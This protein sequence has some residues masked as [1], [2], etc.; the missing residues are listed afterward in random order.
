[1]HSWN[2]SGHLFLISLCFQGTAR[3]RHGSVCPPTRVTNPAVGWEGGEGGSRV[4]LPLLGNPAGLYMLH[5]LLKRWEIEHITCFLHT[6]C[7]ST[8]TFVSHYIFSGR[9]Y[10][11]GRKAGIVMAFADSQLSY[12]KSSTLLF[13]SASWFPSLPQPQRNPVEKSWISGLYQNKCIRGSQIN[14]VWGIIVLCFLNFKCLTLH[15]INI[16]SIFSS[17][18]FNCCGEPLATN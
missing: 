16:H 7:L 11:S 2:N 1:M 17:F 10:S 4:K 8:S 9:M 14:I 3:F 12:L 5:C 13:A 6:W 15:L 18:T